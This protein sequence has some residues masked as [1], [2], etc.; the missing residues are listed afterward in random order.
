ME[1]TLELKGADGEKL[2]VTTVK[3]E[4]VTAY[5]LLGKIGGIIIPA[6]LAARDGNM[7]SAVDQLFKRLTPELM[8]SAMLD[9]LP[10]TVVVRPDS[11]GKLERIE[12]TSIHKINRACGN[13][14]TLLRVMQHALEVN[15]GD[16]F[17]GSDALSSMI[18]TPS[19]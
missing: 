9:L 2:E 15:Y 10:S 3:F 19:P 1:K 16:F 5:L 7:G 6:G 12:L 17:E 14:K 4:P 11:E 13:L 18:P 8:Q